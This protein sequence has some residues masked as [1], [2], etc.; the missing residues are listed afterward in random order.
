MRAVID[1]KR[2]D[3][4]GATE[5]AEFANGWDKGNW[6]FFEEALYRTVAGSW[7]LA[8]SGGPLSKYAR[9]EGVTGRC[10][11]ERITPLTEAAAQDWLEE[12]QELAA[13]E[14]YFGDH[15]MDA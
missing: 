1:G 4:T 6:H 5:V 2:Y 14:A 3:T 13:L 8:G 10:S 15:I 12:H 7:F 9:S 11:G